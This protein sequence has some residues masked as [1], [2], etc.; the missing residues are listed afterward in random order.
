LVQA[1]L[2]LLAKKQKVATEIILYLAPS[3]LRVAEEVQA[4]QPHL[5][6][7]L[8]EQTAALVVVDQEIPT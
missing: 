5:E 7:L 8:L 1:V 6:Q 4:E 2:A 3:L